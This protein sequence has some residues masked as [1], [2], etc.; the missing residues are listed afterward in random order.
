MPAARS[1]FAFR[2]REL[3]HHPWW[4][5]LVGAHPEVADT[6]RRRIRDEG[7]LRSQ[8]M[9]GQSGKGWWDLKVAKKQH[10]QQDA[11]KPVVSNAV[12]GG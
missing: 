6:L 9:E 5:D 10:L 2:R 11:V 12:E 8:E 1:V 3:V 4:G 7:P